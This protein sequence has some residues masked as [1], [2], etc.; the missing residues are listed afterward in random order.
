LNGRVYHTIASSDGNPLTEAHYTFADGYLVVAPSRAL[1][2]RALQVRANGVGIIRST[3]FLALLPRDRY[4]NC[5]AIVYQNLGSTLAPLAGLLGSLSSSLDPKSREAIGQIGNL[6]PMLIAA[7][8]E[9]DRI[10]VAGTGEQ[11]KLPLTALLTG[12]LSGIAGGAIPFGG[13]ER[14]RRNLRKDQ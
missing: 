2:D 8:G 3:G 11:F 14:G 9:P 10:E 4:A 5:S 7:Y 1:V 6:K 12:S 13:R